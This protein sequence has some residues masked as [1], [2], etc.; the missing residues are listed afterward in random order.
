MKT[1]NQKNLFEAVPN[2]N[3]P[4]YNSADAINNIR[5]LYNMW[6]AGL[7]GGNIM[8]EDNNPNL[9]WDSEQNYLYFT[10]PM[11]LNYQRDSYKLW[12]AALKT[13]ND[14]ETNYLFS[15]SKVIETD[16]EQIKLDLCKYK[17]A[18]Q[19]NKQSYIWV[20][21]CNTI[22][23]DLDGSIK[24]LFRYNNYTVSNV[25]NE[26]QVKNKKH[27]PYLSGNKIA[28]Y[29]L[30]VMINYTSLRL[31]DKENIS[32]APDTHV[33]QATQK[34]GLIKDVN[35]SNAQ[36][37]TIEIWQ[38]ILKG[39]ELKQIDIHTPMWLW[40]RGGFIPIVRV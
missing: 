36:M 11:A 22:M 12:E 26:I 32:V 7:L 38:R 2:I 37:Q 33:I 20:T 27:Y 14:A 39:S 4:I 29:W 21:L 34:L 23:H 5:M 30:Y 40:S 18:L 25:L 35:A 19:P 24:N 15:P 10:L 6:K 1:Y 9:N 16:P 8:P 13:Y 31:I 28:N 3:K 17:V